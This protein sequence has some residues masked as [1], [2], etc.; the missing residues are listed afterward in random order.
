VRGSALVVT[1][2]GPLEDGPGGKAAGAGLRAH[3]ILLHASREV[4]QLLSAPH[5]PTPIPRTSDKRICNPWK[6]T[7]NNFY[8]GKRICNPLTI[9]KNNFYEGWKNAALTTFVKTF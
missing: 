9:T 4:A 5:L 6:I 2:A 3:R 8:E 1:P 7:K